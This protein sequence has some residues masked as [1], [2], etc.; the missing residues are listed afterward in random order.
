MKMRVLIILAR[1]A[2]KTSTHRQKVQSEKLIKTAVMI[3][4]RKLLRK[5]F[6]VRNTIESES[7]CLSF[8]EVCGK[9]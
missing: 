1:K 2:K 8:E 6:K 9:K 4:L 3:R 5:I 7:L